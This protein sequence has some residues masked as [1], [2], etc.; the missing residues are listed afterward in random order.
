M[1]AIEEE[2]FFFAG[3]DCHCGLSGFEGLDEEA[4]HLEEGGVVEIAVIVWGGGLCDD[5]S[6]RGVGGADV[7]GFADVCYHGI[8]AAA[9]DVCR[10]LTIPG[11]NLDVIRLQLEEIHPP[12]NPNCRILGVKPIL[13]R[14][15][16]LEEPRCN[17][18]HPRFA[19]S[20][21][22]GRVCCISE[23]SPSYAGGWIYPGKGSVTF[24][25]RSCVFC[26]F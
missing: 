18:C 7:G 16:A 20:V 15:H 24:V 2:N 26:V 11:N 13:V 17:A 19:I 6:W 25:L 3:V 5:G 14:R 21:T 9:E 1:E 12:I 8:I 23:I 10:V 22:L 4:G